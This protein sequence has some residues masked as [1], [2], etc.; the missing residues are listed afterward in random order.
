[1][2][3]KVIIVCNS[4]DQTRRL[5][6][7]WIHSQERRNFRLPPKQSND[8]LRKPRIFLWRRK[9][10]K[11]HLPV[12]P[13]LI[14]RNPG[15]RPC[16]IARFLFEFIRLRLVTVIVASDDDFLARRRHDCE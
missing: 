14:R 7:K 8:Q 4:T 9:G 6:W 1:P 16:E 12:E 13:R 3:R 11:P 2:I 10:G 5:S 15:Q